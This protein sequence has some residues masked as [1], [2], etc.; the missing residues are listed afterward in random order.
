MKII[1][2]IE[3]YPVP[4]IIILVLAIFLP[5]LDFLPVSIMEARNFI[6]ARE[7]VSDGNWIFTSMNG[8]PRYEKPPFP[9]WSTA[10]FGLIFGIKSVF[11]LR[12]PTVIMVCLLG[13]FVYLFSN[14]FLEKKYSLINGLIVVSSLYV[15]V[16]TT[17]APW[18]IYAHTFMFLAIYYL[19]ASFQF[20]RIKYIVYASM[21]LACSILSKGP[22]ALYVLFVP[23]VMSYGFIYGFKR[24]VIFKTISVLVLGSLL[25]S[26]W[27]LYIREFDS[28]SFSQITSKETGNWLSYNVRP[29]YYYWNFFLQTGLWS[30]F[31]FIGLM[32]P[33]LKS[34]VPNIKTYE[35]IF[36]WTVFS[37]I[38][39]SLVPE[40]KTRYL[41][42]VLIPLAMNTGF[43]IQYI[44]EN[45][46][47]FT[48][49]IEKLPVLLH[50]SLLILV[51]FSIPFLLYFYFDGNFNLNLFTVIG[52]CLIIFILGIIILINLFRSNI[53]QL[54]Y[55]SLVFFLAVIFLATSVVNNF[56]NPNQNFHSLQALKEQ[57]EHEGMDVYFLDEISPEMIWDYGSIIPPLL[58]KTGQYQFSKDEKIGVLLNN[59]LLIE[60]TLFTNRFE[61]QQSAIYDLNRVDI[62]SSKHKSRLVNYYYIFKRK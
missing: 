22:V 15:I 39:L 36:Y 46:K 17:E 48:T 13:V 6:T 28:S 59:P 23:F 52:I 45:Y 27:F 10:I 24:N 35:F 5:S 55:L 51:A 53:D 47:R 60:D 25:G 58:K 11:A 44:R 7:M 43:Y 33:Y 16:I 4:S 57:A 34:K 21:Y 32:Y 8:L 1:R 20:E 18:D 38:L 14:K 41:M 12:F 26:V 61:I 42:P 31:A 50:F 49:K 56:L 30:I 3:T 40:K 37:V 29:F 62:N 54:I 2:I 19:Y 9:T